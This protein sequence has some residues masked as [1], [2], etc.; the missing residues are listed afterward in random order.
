MSDY[1]RRYIALAFTVTA[2]LVAF[3][4][5]NPMGWAVAAALALV[6]VFITPFG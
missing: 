5:F 4:W 6:A 3:S 2:W 1:D